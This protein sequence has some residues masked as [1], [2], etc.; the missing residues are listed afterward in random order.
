MGIF[1]WFP[2]ESTSPQDCNLVNT[3]DIVGS[4]PIEESFNRS[5]EFFVAVAGLAGGH[6]I[7]SR[8]FPSP[9]QAGMSIYLLKLNQANQAQRLHSGL[10]R[11]VAS[12]GAF[13]KPGNYARQSNRREIIKSWHLTAAS[14]PRLA[15]HESP[16][17]NEMN[18]IHFATR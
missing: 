4:Y 14:V 18:S 7:A 10:P 17:P 6:H 8:A 3:L 15:R 5:P 1:V 11:T 16:L 9:R 13:D 2:Y 12:K